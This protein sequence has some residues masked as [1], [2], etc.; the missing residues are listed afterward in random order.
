MNGK[1]VQGKGGGSGKR[2]ASTPAKDDSV[3]ALHALHPLRVTWLAMMCSVL[4]IVLSACLYTAC[5]GAPLILSYSSHT[6]GSNGYSTVTFSLSSSNAAV[7]AVRDDPADAPMF[8]VSSSSMPPAMHVPLPPPL[9]AID[10]ALPA[11]AATRKS[12]AHNT[13]DYSNK[14]QTGAP[15][16]LL[17]TH[18]HKQGSSTHT[19]NAFS[20]LS[21]VVFSPFRMLRNMIAGIGRTIG[22]FLFRTARV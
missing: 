13:K 14:A 11:V 15:G 17:Q 2:T 16:S 4:L 12:R 18:K 1:A 10:K 9:P 7:S 6:Y 19:K 20:A 22:R 21:K 3:A 8:D 5:F